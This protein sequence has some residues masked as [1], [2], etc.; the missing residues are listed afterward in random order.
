[1]NLTQWLQLHRSMRYDG[2]IKIRTYNVFSV[3]VIWVVI[4]DFHAVVK[5]EQAKNDSR[6]LLKDA[7]LVK[8]RVLQ[9]HFM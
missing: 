9:R 3:T 5:G 8:T 2:L 7:Q 6:R 4:R 1:M